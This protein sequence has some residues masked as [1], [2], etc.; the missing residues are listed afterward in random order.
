MEQTAAQLTDP[1][2]G[3]YH[4]RQNSFRQEF[5]SEKSRQKDDHIAGGLLP[6]AAG[7]QKR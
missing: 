6:A 5:Q 3:H 4:H 2:R 1:G 7:W